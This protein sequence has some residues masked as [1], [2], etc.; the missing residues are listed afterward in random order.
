MLMQAAWVGNPECESYDRSIADSALERGDVD[1]R[2]RFGARD[3]SDAICAA[4]CP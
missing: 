4:S 1:W 3:G 2:E